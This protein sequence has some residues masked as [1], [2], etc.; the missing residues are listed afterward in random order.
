MALK[1]K[2]AAAIAA[3]ATILALSIT[4]MATGATAAMFNVDDAWVAGF[5]DYFDSTGGNP[6]DS[7]LVR[8]QTCSD[9]YM[10]EITALA[11]LYYTKGD[12]TRIE[13]KQ[14]VECYSK[15]CYADAKKYTFAKGYK[16]VGKHTAKR[17]GDTGT[18]WTVVEW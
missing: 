12:E 10:E 14:T 3:I 4:A 8:A 2:I 17:N 16:G 11:M 1:K 7:D 5:V 15:A 13:S 18:D 9:E 6:F